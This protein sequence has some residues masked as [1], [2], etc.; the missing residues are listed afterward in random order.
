M[1]FF[2]YRNN[3]YL[4]NSIQS[5]KKLN[6]QGHRF[7]IKFTKAQTENMRPKIVENQSPYIDKKENQIFLKCKEI[8]KWSSCKVIEDYL[9]ISLYCILGSPSSC[10]T[11]QL[12]HSEF[13]NIWGKLDILQIGKGRQVF[14][15]SWGRPMVFFCGW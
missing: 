13:P 12:L 8:Q 3:E 2:S 1:F 9:H 4:C 11:L 6:I 15:K 7:K 14:V 5:F 10:V